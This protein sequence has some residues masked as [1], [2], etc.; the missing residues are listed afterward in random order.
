MWWSKFL[1]KNQK[2]CK[3]QLSIKLK[4]LYF[5]TILTRKKKLKIRLFLKPPFKSILRI[6]IA[7]TSSKTSEKIPA[8][9]F[10]ITGK[11]SFWPFLAQ[12]SYKMFFLKY[13]GFFTFG[14]K[15]TLNSW[16]VDKT[17]MSK[18][19]H[20]YKQTNGWCVFHRT[21]THFA[22]Q[23]GNACQNIP[24][25]FKLLPQQLNFNQYFRLKLWIRYSKQNCFWLSW[26]CLCSRNPR[27]IRNTLL[28]M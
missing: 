28:Y 16:R 8:C 17:F 10:D 27:K 5:R 22:S 21:F 20:K 18:S 15:D 2:S 25:N 23:Q 4:K 14:V 1:P 3:G 12:K 9:N 6:Y 19:E 11:I 24:W 26:K 7:V 13:F